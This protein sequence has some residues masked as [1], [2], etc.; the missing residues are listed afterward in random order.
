MNLFTRSFGVFGLDSLLLDIK[1]DVFSG[2]CMCLVRGE[3]G[4]EG[5]PRLQ[6]APSGF[7]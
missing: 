7:G 1:A 4:G 5:L 6:M 3:R 2:V